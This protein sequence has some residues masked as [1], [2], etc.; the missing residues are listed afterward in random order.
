MSLLPL[1]FIKSLGSVHLIL[2][3]A[4]QDPNEVFGRPEE[5]GKGE[6]NK[7]TVFFFPKVTSF[8]TTFK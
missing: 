7:V 1:N 5:V 6:Q 4:L 2:G 3:S 8:Q